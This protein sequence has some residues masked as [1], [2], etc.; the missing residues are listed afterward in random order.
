[1]SS[2]KPFWKGKKS[3]DLYEL[4]VKIDCASGATLTGTLMGKD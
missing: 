4:G 1:M 2:E 3:N